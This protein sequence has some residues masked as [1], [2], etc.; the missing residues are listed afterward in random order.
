VEIIK[1]TT[2]IDNACSKSFIYILLK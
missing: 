1:L 2:K